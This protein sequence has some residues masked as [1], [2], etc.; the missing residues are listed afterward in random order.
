MLSRYFYTLLFIPIFLL[1]AC[2]GDESSEPGK[3]FSVS[4]Q[5]LVF[6][7]ATPAVS[8]SSQASNGNLVETPIDANR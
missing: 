8:V 7:A 5:A 6:D 3:Q 4:T 2:G 1:S